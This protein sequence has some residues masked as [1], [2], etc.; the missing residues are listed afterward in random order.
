MLG[1][2]SLLGL[3]VA[4]L[5]EPVDEDLSVPHDGAEGLLP[6]EDLLE[7]GAVRRE[8][9]EV[10]A[11]RVGARGDELRDADG[12]VHEVRSVGAV[13]DAPCR[14][15]RAGRRRRVRVVLEAA[16]VTGSVSVSVSVLVT[17]EGEQ[18]EGRTR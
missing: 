16:R 18:G 7:G 17:Q 15:S 13:G 8:G 10:Q 9:L 14:E 6:G 5:D 1:L 12:R 3:L 11:L 2:V 4:N